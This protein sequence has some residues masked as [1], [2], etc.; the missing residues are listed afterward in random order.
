MPAV[1]S[2]SQDIEVNSRW[3]VLELTRVVKNPPSRSRGRTKP[4]DSL[5]SAGE[6]HC[7]SHIGSSEIR[8]CNTGFIVNH[9][10]AKANKVWQGVAELGVEG[11]EEEA[12]YVKRILNNE[13]KEE[14][15]RRLSEQQ[16]QGNP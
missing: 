1:Q 7:C 14:S 11:D 8:N 15:A 9:E 5:S 3:T 13:K 4:V 10:N 6:I 2:F 16:K 12:Q